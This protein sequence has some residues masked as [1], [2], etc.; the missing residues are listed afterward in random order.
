MKGRSVQRA[1]SAGLAESEIRAFYRKY[2]DAIHDKRL[3][4][5]HPLRRYVHRSLH[6]STLECVREFAEPGARVLDA[7]CGE[8]ALAI[9]IAAMLDPQ[10]SVVGIDLSEPNIAAAQ[11]RVRDPR[12]GAKVN[13]HVADLEL[14]PYEDDSFEI[15]VSSHVLEHLPNFER[16]LTELRRVSRDVVVFGLPTCMNPCAMVI[17]GGDNYWQVSRHTPY[18]LWLGMWR[19]LTHLGSEGVDQGYVGRNDLPHVWRFPWVLRRQVEDAGYEI[20]RF[21]APTLPLPYIGSIPGALKL[22]SKIDRLRKKPVFRSL[23]YGSIV[24]ARKNPS[25]NG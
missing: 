2:H 6:T 16:G 17:L 9:D 10:A 13:F 11:R 15:V 1:E 25:S 18:A 21:E 5:P 19:V 4:S 12:D 8:G 20:L 3:D 14:L 22:Q 23:G 7:G 24:I